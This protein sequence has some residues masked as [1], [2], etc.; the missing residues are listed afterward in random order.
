[1]DERHCIASEGAS[2]FG[3][4]AKIYAQRGGERLLVQNEERLLQKSFFG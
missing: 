3:F 2:L 1:M 4:M